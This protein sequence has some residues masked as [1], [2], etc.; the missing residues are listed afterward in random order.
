VSQK[1]LRFLQRL[2]KK[3]SGLV[4]K[5]R[6]KRG[7]EDATTDHEA[8]EGDK[9]ASLPPSLPASPVVGSRFGESEGVTVGD[10]DAEPFLIEDSTYHRNGRNK[11]DSTHNSGG[12][13]S[14]ALTALTR[15]ERHMSSEPL[16]CMCPITNAIMVDP[17]Q[18]SD[19]YTYERSAIE[20]WLQ[21]Q[22]RRYIPMTSPMTRAPMKSSE[23]V[24]NRAIRD[25]IEK[26]REQSLRSYSALPGAA[27]GG[28]I[29]ESKLG[30]GTMKADHVT[31]TVAVGSASRQVAALRISDLGRE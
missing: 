20:Q 28:S 16:F 1:E 11:L 27:E 4:I 21:Q 8:T 5:L 9:P 10:L 25:A 23:L 18:A 17:V 13:F 29:C 26:F 24:P 15:K 14:S 7:S 12:S 22:Q 19:G 6:A 2:Q 30:S 3:G 31:V